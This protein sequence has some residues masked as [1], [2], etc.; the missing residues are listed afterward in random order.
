MI[1][2]K[3]RHLVGGP[4]IINRFVQIGAGCIILPNVI[5][6]EGV[7]VGSM[8][9]IKR[10]LKEWSVY[11][12]IPAKYIKKRSKKIL[13]LINLSNDD[14]SEYIHDNPLKTK[15]KFIKNSTKGNNVLLKILILC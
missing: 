6:N 4:V 8:S 13:E 11:A 3:Y 12:G 14:F 10:S 2:Q 9:L 5:I 1:N 15:T 7:V